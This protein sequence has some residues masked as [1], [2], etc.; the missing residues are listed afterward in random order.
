MD[1]DV[2]RMGEIA[3]LDAA[4][5][6]YAAL[7]LE[8]AAPDNTDTEHRINS[9][10]GEALKSRVTKKEAAKKIIPTDPDRYYREFSEKSSVAQGTAWQSA[11]E[12]FES[13]E[14]RNPDWDTLASFF[15][16][17]PTGEPQR[18]L[19]RKLNLF[20]GVQGEASTDKNTIAALIEGRFAVSRS[21]YREALLAFR[22][23][24]S[25][26]DGE[27]LFLSHPELLSDLGKAFQYTAPAEGIKRFLSMAAAM[28]DA[29]MAPAMLDRGVHVSDALYRLFYYAGRMARQMKKAREASDY[30][31]LAVPFASDGKDVCIWYIFDIAYNEK[32]ESVVPFIKKYAPFWNDASYFDDIFDKISFFV[33]KNRKWTVLTDVFDV[34]NRYASAE[35]RAKYAYIIGRAVQLGFLE[36][37]NGIERS[38]FYYKIAYSAI[39]TGRITIPAFYYRTLAAKRLSLPPDFA[40]CISQSH[41]AKSPPAVQKPPM[42][43][44]EIKFLDGFFDF[45]CSAAAYPF[46]RESFDRLTLA[47]VR[48]FLER[49]AAAKQWRRLINLTVLCR[50]RN[51]FKPER[52][53]LE[54]SYPQ[55]FK[56]D[57][58][59]FAEK[60]GIAP[61]LLFAL[62][63]QESVFN[64]SA[65]SRAGASGLTQLMERTAQD[66]AHYLAR[67]GGPDYRVDGTVNLVDPNINLHLG[68]LYYR[69]LLDRLGNAETAVL[70][71][72]GGIGRIRRWRRAETELPDDLFL[73]SVEL[74]ET[75]EYG[76]AVL[77]GQAVY[78]FLYYK[79]D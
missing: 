33:C 53:D 40:A 1:A 62:V 70:A 18:W 41:V 23:A 77:G 73:E 43:A 42:S 20:L 38:G 9:L 12:I 8:N 78:D 21:S 72:N 60:A 19:F 47:Q 3:R 68:A 49:L 11:F 64:P 44:D 79:S 57:I 15:F 66:M 69:E 46:L 4:A 51:D 31:E 35:T 39:E 16:D 13:V 24:L 54:L 10:L 34:I 76:R 30:F 67:N 14:Q 50:E 26:A 45:G 37:K 28:A 17:G 61:A 27:A 65:Y 56:A 59:D 71:Y 58:E 75:R 36:W 5:P 63:R 32:P 74:T 48:W 52:R 7:L 55:G 25:A 2:S 22:P 6:F 29:A